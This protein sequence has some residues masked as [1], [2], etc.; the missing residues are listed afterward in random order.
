ME[1][2]ERKY[3]TYMDIVDGKNDQKYVFTDLLITRLESK[4]TEDGKKVLS[5]SAAISNCEK[6][7]SKAFGKEVYAKDGTVWADVS[8]WEDQAERLEKLLKGGDKVK[9]ILTGRISLREW[10][11]ANGEPRQRVRINVNSWN[12]NG[13]P[14]ASNGATSEAQVETQTD[15]PND[16]CPF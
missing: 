11:T 16:E 3:Y 12:A 8:F 7:L 15:A 9:V 6:K 1:K 10:N 14:A 5:G 13:R 2:N 4:T